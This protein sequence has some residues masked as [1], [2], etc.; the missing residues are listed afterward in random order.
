M[1]PSS[2]FVLMSLLTAAF[3]PAQVGTVP[4]VGL[5]MSGGFPLPVT[6][7]QECGPFVC[8]PIPSAPI[9]RG[10]ART[11]THY[12]APN[13]LF[14]MGVGTVP[15]FCVPVAGIANDLMLGNP[16]LTIG[17][18][19]TSALNPA[20]PCFQGTGQVVLNVPAGAPIGIAFNVQSVG[21]SP[22]TGLLAFS[23]AIASAIGI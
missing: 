9:S 10:G 12:A 8:A 5:T 4:D 21:F 15:L 1:H 14:A 20:T 7:G 22:S 16:I 18:G 3:A 19:Y 17:V 23:P 13:T 11:M 6:V 2:A